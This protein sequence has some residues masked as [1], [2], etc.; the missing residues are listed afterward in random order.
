M[1]AICENSLYNKCSCKNKYHLP[2]ALPL[3]DGHCHIDLF[4]RYEFNKN[5]F[6]TQFANGRKM[7]FID[8]KH[9]YYRWFTDYH[10]DN[11]NVKI[12]TTYGIHPKYLPSDISH[13]VKELENIFMNK[14]NTIITEEVAIGECGLDSTSSSSLELQLTVFKMQLKLAAQLNLP[15]VLHGRGTESFNLMFNELKLHLNS[16]HRIHWHCINPKSDLNVIT[17]FLNYFENSYIGLNCSIFSHD[18]IES[19]TL[20]H[21]WLV[22]VENIIYKIILE[23]DFPFLKPSILESKQ[24]NPISGITYTAQHLVNIL[25]KKNLNTTKIIDQSNKNIQ[26]MFGID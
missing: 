20:F 19:Q 22:S 6:H 17:A 4:F 7:T 12:F 24:Y 3:Y 16:T 25:R 23:T 15:V 14:Y 26:K 13:V 18:D 10:L 1:N 5:D 21:K 11:P 2:L 8:N 9:Q